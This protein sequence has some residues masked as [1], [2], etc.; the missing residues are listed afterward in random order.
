MCRCAVRAIQ[1]LRYFECM[2]KSAATKSLTVLWALLLLWSCVAAQRERDCGQSRVTVIHSEES[3]LV[4]T[5]RALDD[6]LSYFRRLDIAV[7]PSVRIAFIDIADARTSLAQA[8]YAHADIASRVV[9]VKTSS[10]GSPWGLAW[11]PSL[12]ASFIRHELVHV[13]LSEFLGDRRAQLPREWHEFLAYAIQLELMEE[14]TRS[15]VLANFQTVVAFRA[16]EEVNEFTYS[17]DPEAF[18]VAAYHTYREW[19]GP[20][21]VR[22][23][24]SSTLSGHLGKPAN[25]Q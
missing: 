13:V 22:E 23:L 10:R 1:H 12:G 21:F 20:R 16:S 17:L 7:Q 3:Q 19:G 9:Y 5:C 14:S 24:L 4:M 2:N 25:Q 18:A 6:T 8:S 11:S 15:K